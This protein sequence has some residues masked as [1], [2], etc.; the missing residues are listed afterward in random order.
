ME[1]RKLPA[2]LDSEKFIISC[3]M[4]NLSK[5]DES[6]ESGI[7]EES[8]T[9]PSLYKIFKYLSNNRDK[10]IDLI[11]ISNYLDSIDEL[12]NVGGNAELGMLYQFAPTEAYFQIHLN[13]V[14]EKERLR[15]V[16][17]R[18]TT[19]I[20]KAYE[21]NNSNELLDEVEKDI[22]SIRNVDSTNTSTESS[23]NLIKKTI[24]DFTD[25]VNGK[26]LLVGLPTRFKI[27]ND[28][29]KGLCKE[30]MIIIAARPSMGKTALMCNLAE[31]LMVSGIPG[32]IFSCEMGNQRLMDRIIYGR[33]KIPMHYLKPG[34]KPTKGDIEGLR[35]AV[36]E[37]RDKPLFIDDTPAIN[38]DNIRAKLRRKKKSENIQWF[39]VDYLQLLT[40]NR[41]SG[42]NREREIS[43]ISAGLKAICKELK[44]PGIIL[45]QLNRGP[46]KRQDGI[47]KMSDLR[48]SGAIE[49]DADIVG[50]LW[51][52]AYYGDDEEE[53]SSDE[54]NKASKIFGKPN[55][56]HSS[57][58]IAKNRNGPTGEVEM[59]FHKE[60]MEF[61]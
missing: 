1:F 51:R 57:L 41:K 44:I 55:G 12:E 36:S 14:I 15:E 9:S 52:K 10:E 8:F 18:C 37:L 7:K 19:S 42:D 53:K 29:T 17:K 11:T 28:L 25:L 21:S 13:K 34:Y 58:I 59:K 16:I 43:E 26:P 6:I 56:E 50:L 24:N 2:S 4:Q 49:Q 46:E 31:D 32:M 38:I 40:T 48:E 39:A 23:S 20:A 33:A 5:I 3:M 22:F 54:S 60:I 35:K 47:P 30:D 45:A 61:V 27:F